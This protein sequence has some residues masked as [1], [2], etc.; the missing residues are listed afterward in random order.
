MMPRLCAIL[1]LLGLAAA[2]R[3]P[4]PLPP[5]RMTDAEFDLWLMPSP[6]KAMH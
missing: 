5:L 3:R 6:S 2:A 4:R 1:V